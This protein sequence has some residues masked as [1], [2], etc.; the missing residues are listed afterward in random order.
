[1]D[2]SQVITHVRSMNMTT[3]L[4]YTFQQTITMSLVHST[5]VRMSGDVVEVT[6]LFVFQ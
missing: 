6:S 2:S 5:L 3:P 4:E 1:M